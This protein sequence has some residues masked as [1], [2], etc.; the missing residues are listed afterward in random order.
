MELEMKKA[1]GPVSYWHHGTFSTVPQCLWMDVYTEKE[2]EKIHYWYEEMKLIT[3]S[4]VG[5]QRWI[6]FFF[7]FY[8]FSV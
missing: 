3:V 5:D 8:I 7:T 2:K 4:T 1:F 6:L